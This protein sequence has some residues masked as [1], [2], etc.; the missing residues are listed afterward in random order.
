VEG[1][2][3]LLAG[4]GLDGQYQFQWR[5][6][7]LIGAQ[8]QAGTQEKGADRGID[9]VISFSIGPHGEVGR[10]IVSVKSQR[11]HRFVDVYNETATPFEWQKREVHQV[12]LSHHC[13]DL[14]NPVKCQVRHP[15]FVG[16]ARST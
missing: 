15:R 13:T 11:R 1:A 9:G 12:S 14:R 6:L 3:A 10:A 16:C 5:A 7:D 2:R 8:P 4:T